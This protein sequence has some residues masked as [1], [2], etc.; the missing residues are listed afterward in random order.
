MIGYFRR[1]VTERL[2]NAKIVV[3][4]GNFCGLRQFFVRKYVIGLKK[5]SYM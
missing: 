3:F 5:C 1:Y 2:L 4:L